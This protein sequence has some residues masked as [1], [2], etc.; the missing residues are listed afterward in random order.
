MAWRFDLAVEIH[1]CT[2]VCLE[3]AGALA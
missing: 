2:T 1:V 3:K